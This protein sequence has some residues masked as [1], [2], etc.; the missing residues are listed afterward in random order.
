MIAI[1]NHHGGKSVLEHLNA[2]LVAAP[3]ASIDDQDEESR[4]G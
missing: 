2:L 3:E 1:I 4:A